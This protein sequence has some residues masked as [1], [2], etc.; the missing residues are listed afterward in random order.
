MVWSRESRRALG[1]THLHQGPQPRENAKN[2]LARGSF[3]EVPGR[4]REDKADFSVHRRRLALDVIN[5]DVGS[6]NNDVVVPWDRKQHPAIGRMGN[7]DGACPR[8]ERFG[9][10]DVRSLAGRHDA[11]RLRFI[12][13]PD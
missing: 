11:S 3:G 9:Q 6:A 1:V 10:D 4:V 13:F 12:H 7:H 5:R 8:Q 2:V